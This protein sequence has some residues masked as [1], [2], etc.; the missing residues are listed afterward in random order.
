MTAASSGGGAAP[1]ILDQETVLQRLAARDAARLADKDKRVQQREQEAVP[2]ESAEAFLESWK[3]QHAEVAAAVQAVVQREGSSAQPT[4]TSLQEASAKFKGLQQDLA[5]AS[6]FL[7][8]YDL[9]QATRALETLQKQLDQAQSEAAPK[10][11]F[12]FGGRK[13]RKSRQTADSAATDVAEEGSRQDGMAASAQPV[14][15]QQPDEAA[16]PLLSEDRGIQGARNQVLVRTA[17][18]LGGDFVLEDLQGCTV[19]LLGRLS[20]LRVRQLRDCRIACG[21]V[22]GA[23]FVDDVRDSTLILASHQVRV[24]RTHATALRLRVRSNP[25]IEHCSSITVAPYLPLRYAGAAEDLESSNLGEDTAALG[26]WSKV[27]DFAWLRSTPSP[28]WAVMPDSQSDGSLEW[29]DASST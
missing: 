20:A 27:Q 15:Q 4:A 13:A 28:N 25:I 1:Q 12:A 18:Q 9:R 29:M 16:Q 23:T 5:S 6:Y 10:Q 8:S 22:A 11:K 17:D 7:P 19:L 21:P 26:L 24:H 2:A 14:A 3:A